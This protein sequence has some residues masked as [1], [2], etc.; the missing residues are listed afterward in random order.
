MPS[1]LTSTVKSS[2]TSAGASIKMR[3]PEATPADCAPTVAVALLVGAGLAVGNTTGVPW[4]LVAVPLAATVTSCI[5]GTS[6][7]VPGTALS[8]PPAF[9]VSDALLAGTCVDPETSLDWAAAAV[10]PA[11]P[12][13]GVVAGL[14]DRDG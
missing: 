1:T 12:T 2:D 10:W 6:A 13:T 14:T 5:G 11:A 4:E 7:V 3:A 9:G 8:A